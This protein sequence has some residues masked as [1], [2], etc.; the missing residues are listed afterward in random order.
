M[1]T[2]YMYNIGFYHIFITF[3]MCL[4]IVTALFFAFAGLSGPLAL[5]V[6]GAVYF[7]MPVLLFTRLSAQ[8]LTAV[9]ELRRPGLKSAVYVLSL[10]VCIYPAALVLSAVTSVFFTNHLPEVV[11]TMATQANPLIMFAA[12]AIS[13]AVFEEV[14]L[15]G[16]LGKPLK[17][18]GL[19]G[20]LL[21]GLYFGLIHLNPH[22]FFYAFALGVLLYYMLILTGS[23][24][25]PILSHFTINSLALT[26]FF[27]ELPILLSDP[28]MALGFFIIPTVIFVFLLKKFIRD[29]SGKLAADEALPSADNKILTPS[30]IVMLAVYFFIVFSFSLF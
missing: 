6:G 30:F 16:M 5:I 1:Y 18:L 19:R 13:P 14:L 12:F 15:R 24:W 21:N 22:Q 4:Q 29:N 2:V 26:L 27:T 7:A 11:G 9:L 23:I 17:H 3:I 28:N 8:K 10:S 20:A 25:A